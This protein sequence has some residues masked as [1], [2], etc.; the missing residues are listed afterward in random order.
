MAHGDNMAGWQGVQQTRQTRWMPPQWHMVT[1]WSS[2]SRARTGTNTG[3][4]AGG[5]ANMSHQ[6]D[7]YTVRR[8]KANK[9][10]YKQLEQYQNMCILFNKSQHT[11]TFQWDEEQ[12]V[13]KSG[14]VFTNILILDLTYSGRRKGNSGW[15]IEQHETHK[16]SNIHTSS[17]WDNH[18]CN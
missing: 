13:L 3:G 16:L 9:C 12:A 7:W 14:P 17:H 8:K 5:P 1:M 10:R 6:A 4:M 18:A 15:T 2:L 11:K